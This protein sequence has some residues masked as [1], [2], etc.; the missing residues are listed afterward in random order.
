MRTTALRKITDEEYDAVGRVLGFNPRGMSFESL[1]RYIV[2]GF[3]FSLVEHVHPVAGGTF[4]V[5]ARLGE[6]EPSRMGF[7]RWEDYPYAR[8]LA[9][10][11]ALA[12]AIERED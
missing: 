5:V 10:F 7:D 1:S 9:V 4:R 11:K 12:R 3:Q 2:E 6:E 8:Y